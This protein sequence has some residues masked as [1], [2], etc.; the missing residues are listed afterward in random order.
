M[1]PK[2]EVDLNVKGTRIEI[3]SKA[4]IKE[5]SKDIPGANFARTGGPHWTVPLTIESCKLL[6]ERFGK[7]LVIGP[8]LRAWALAKNDRARRMKALGKSES[9]ELPGLWLAKQPKLWKA[10]T[11]GRKYQSSG[12]R[13]ISEGRRVIVSDTVGLGKTAQAFAGILDAE[14]AGPYLVICPKTAVTATWKPEVQ[15]WLKG[16][17]PIAMPEGREKRNALLDAFL[18]DPQPTDWVIVNQDMLRT[19]AYWQCMNWV[20]APE[21]SKGRKRCGVLTFVKV[22]RKELTCEHDPT[23]TKTVIEHEYPQLFKG[24]WGAIVADESHKSLLIQNRVPSQTRRGMD[25]LRV[26]KGGIK[27]AQSATPWRSRPHLL[28]STLNWLYPDEYTAKWA[29]IEIMYDVEEAYRDGPKVIGQLDPDREKLLYRTLNSVMIR[30]TRKEVAKHLPARLYIGHSHDPE[31]EETPRGIWLPMEGKQAKAYKQMEDDAVA[32]VEGGEIEAIGALAELTRC[33]QFA[34]SYGRVDEAGSFKPSLPSNKF[35]YLVDLLHELGFPDDP[36]T[37][38]IVVSRFTQLLE[39]FAAEVRK[40]H[41]IESLMLTGRTSMK[42]REEVRE[43]FNDPEAQPHLLF[44]NTIA[45]GTAIT[46]DA[47]DEMVFLDETFV[48]DDQ[49]QVEGRNDNRR[50]EER[51]VQRRYRY[52]RSLESVEVGVAFVN[53]AASAEDRRLLDERRGVQYVVDVLEQTFRQAKPIG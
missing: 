41:K 39:L 3:W 36:T 13:F 12:A 37:K 7:R 9:A 51:I 14:V 4:K 53:S 34:S 42:K 40:Q 52:L 38:V 17:R 28:W 43:I 8:E 15:T 31:D 23:K 16:H 50:P 1:N 20:D 21:E 49:E 11:Q 5:L 2:V 44:L 47:A 25:L 18:S 27:I 30:R 35:D 29:W 48:A 46:L 22:G 24:R 33:Q 32:E 45:G 19:R 10:V 6:R 26:K